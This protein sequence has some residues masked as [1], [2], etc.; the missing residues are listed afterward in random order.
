L[1]KLTQEVIE[2]LD[3]PSHF[4]FFVQHNLPNI[5]YPR[6][7]IIQIL[8]N[9]LNNS[10]KYMDKPNPLITISY[11]ENANFYLI[12]V[13]DNGRGI[14]EN[15]L[16]EIFTLFETA[17]PKDSKVESYGIGLAIVKQ[18]VEEN[19]G[20]IWVDSIEDKETKFHFTVPK[21]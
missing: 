14:P 18:L 20:T 3:P 5:K 9:L 8:Q 13:T 19:G 2:T 1:F 12:C 15:K 4:H 11:T 7:S 16:K 21:K 6:T 17:N 10:I